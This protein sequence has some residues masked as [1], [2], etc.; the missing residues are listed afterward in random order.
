MW[1]AVALVASAAAVGAVYANSDGS[2]RGAA[3]RTGLRVA[4][5]ISPSRPVRF[6]LILRLPGATRLDASLQAI[7]DPRSA[8]YHHFIPPSQFG[9]RFGVGAKQLRSL[10]RRLAVR[11]L[12][13]T[14]SYPQRTALQFAGTASAVERVFGIRLLS[15]ADGR[16]RRFQAPDRQPTIPAYMRSI[17]IAVNG[18]DTR[19]SWQPLDVPMGGLTPKSISSAYGLHGLSRLGMRGQRRKIAIISFSDYDHSDP[20]GYAGQFGLPGPPPRVISVDGGT[21]D[22]SH[23]DEANLDIDVVKAV[24]PDAQI[25]V[26]EAPDTD[27]GYTD[28]INRIVKDR[29]ATIISSSWGQ[30]EP[31]LSRSRLAG[32]LTALK[33]A[34]A[35]GISMFAAT[36]DQ[37]AY[38]CQ[39]QD[40]TDLHLSVDWPAASSYAVAV[41]GTRLNLTSNGTYESEYAWDDVLEAG[42]G[43]GGFAAGP[44]PRWQI[45]PGV[46][47]TDRHRGLPDV[48]ADAD[49]G[50]G[51]TIYWNGGP[52]TGVGGTSAAAPFWAASTLLVS[53]Y[54]AAHRTGALGYVNPMLYALAARPRPR[55][56]FNDVTFGG[57]RYYQAGP[58]WDPATGLG[59][60]NVYNL[61]VDT[62]AYLRSVARGRSHGRHRRARP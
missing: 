33:A 28:V 32:D 35:A 55:P 12:E 52:V 39:A 30:C 44:R 56:A 13:L 46:P 14:V 27:S 4:G 21:T 3:T 53:Q 11:G 17:V 37:G 62:V 20:Q 58:G 40:P 36:G 8:Q 25:L 15:F 60:P 42:G 7:N 61:A 38:D 19:P 43:G 59:S 45:G 10:E 5:P 9:A 22:I 1:V 57:N 49:A 34:V 50:T 23:A 29:R 48:S 41:G 54:A 26:Y 31:R 18:L 24:A 6:T 16:G 47:V 51:W 2:S